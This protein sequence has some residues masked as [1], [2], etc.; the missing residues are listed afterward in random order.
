MTQSES[1]NMP[2]K[3]I[4]FSLPVFLNLRLLKTVGEKP[5]FGHA[6]VLYAEALVFSKVFYEVGAILG[7]AWKDKMPTAF[8]MFGFGDDI[9]YFRNYWGDKVRKR[10]EIYK[11]KPSSFSDF[12]GET[13]V[14]IYGIVSLKDLFNKKIKVMEAEEMIVSSTLEGILFGN[15][16]TELTYQILRKVYEKD[17]KST[18]DDM[19]YF[20]KIT[21]L[22]EPR[23]K[24]PTQMD[25]EKEIME[26]IRSYVDEYFPELTDDLG[27][28]ES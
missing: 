17:K 15:L 20:N 3:N 25:K 9:K 22:G 8:Q 27:I 13:D 24:I 2:D 4:P 19:E 7:C 18:W 6:R 12:I 5:I 1:V 16:Y 28:R 21:L 26:L 14:Q 10:L 11:E 23:N